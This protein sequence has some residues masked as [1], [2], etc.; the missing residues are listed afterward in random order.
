[1]STND[2][3][4]EILEKADIVEVVSDYVKLE[5]AGSSYKGLCPFHNDSNPSFFVSP[6]KKICKCMVCGTGGNAITILEKLAKISTKEAITRL[7]ERYQIK[8]DFKTDS[9][10]VGKKSLF[11]ITSYAAN[12][13]NYYLTHSSLFSDTGRTY[14]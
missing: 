11:Q 12:F 9:K 6:S 1:M 14:S 4:N 8:V 2:V 10:T 7:A 5:K 13:Y 3:I